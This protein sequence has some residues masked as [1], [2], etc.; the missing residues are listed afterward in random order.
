MVGG[1]NWINGSWW[2]LSHELAARRLPAAA[3]RPRALSARRRRPRSRGTRPVERTSKQPHPNQAHPGRQM[4]AEVQ[5]CNVRHIWSGPKTNPGWEVRRHDLNL[6]RAP[7]CFS[8][9]GRF[10]L[11]LRSRLARRWS[12]RFSSSLPFNALRQTATYH[13]P[14]THSPPHSL[15]WSASAPRRPSVCRPSRARSCSRLLSCEFGC[16]SRPSA[17]SS[18]ARTSRRPGGTPPSWTGSPRPYI[19]VWG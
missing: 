3:A 13:S 8:V 14:P 9:R 15:S 6:G 7:C 2:S 10:G 19:R 12:E 18:A 4:T 5:E 16:A 17:H 1:S 11:V